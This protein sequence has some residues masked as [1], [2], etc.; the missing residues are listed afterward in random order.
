MIQ[1]KHK[2]KHFG[3]AFVAALTRQLWTIRT[4]HAIPTRA[5]LKK[6]QSVIFRQKR[7]DD[8]FHGRLPISEKAQFDL[9]TGRNRNL[10]TIDEQNTLRN[11]VV[12]IFGLSV[13][14]H[15]ALTW[16]M[17][18]RAVTIKI[19]DP[20][21]I[22]ASNL[23]RIRTGWSHVGEKKVD[24]VKRE[25]L[26]MH[27]DAHILSFTQTDT[28]TVEK[29]FR[30]A[31]KLD[32]I[33]DEIDDFPSKILLRQLAKKYHIP[34]V[35]A[36]DVGDNV[37]VDIER[38]DRE[39][40][41]ELFLGRIPHIESIDFHRLTPEERKKL[42]IRH[43]G[44]D[45]YSERMVESIVA[46]GGSIPTWPQ[47]GATATVAGGIVA[48][49]AKKILLGEEVANGRYVVS[50]DKLFVSDFDEPDR[51]LGRQKKITQFQTILEK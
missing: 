30:T 43:I 5:D 33:V 4:P 17:E 28:G 9:T 6:L 18:S 51:M 11:S 31:P 2:P 40:Q 29:M 49:V 26:D 34:L 12:G 32:L 45:L 36:A 25:L 38:Y 13:G 35:S 37:M 19:A 44:F 50:L 3:N 27:P 7:N 47:L 46:I 24:A 48:T 39:P 10:I 20:D 1:T 22:E 15:A 21:R 16:M 14:S 8:P 41:P 23:N 42:I